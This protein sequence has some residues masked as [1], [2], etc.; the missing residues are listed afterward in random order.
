MSRPTFDEPFVKKRIER[1]IDATARKPGHA[2]DG[3]STEGAIA[4]QREVNMS[5]GRQETELLQR[6]SEI[7]CHLLSNNWTS[8]RCQVILGGDRLIRGQRGL[9]M[10]AEAD[11]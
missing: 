6:Q 8:D 1:Q 4:N 11:V 7:L 5:L 10:W 2:G 9:A 3:R